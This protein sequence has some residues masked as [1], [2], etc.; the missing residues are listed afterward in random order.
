MR[1]DSISSRR[2]LWMVLAIAAVIACCCLALLTGV[3]A[4]IRAGVSLAETWSAR[5]PI[6]VT[7]SR[8][9]EQSFAVAGPARLVVDLDVGALDIVAAD[10]DTITVSAQIEVRGGNRLAAAQLLD[11][12]RFDASQSGS[13][14]TVT[15]G[16]PVGAEWR[17]ASPQIDVRITVPRRTHVT[18]DMKAGDMTLTGVK[19]DIEITADVGRVRLTNVQAEKQLSVA[20]NVAEISFSGALTADASYRLMSNVG[21]IRMTLPSNSAFAIDATS[22]VGAV[23]V[24]FDVVGEASQQKVGRSVQGVVDGDNRTTVYLRSDV[25]AIS[26]QPE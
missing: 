9:F 8:T 12:V 15:S 7:T 22:N 6:A 18:I 13:T 20:T 10:Q 19:G 24:G 17:N 26:V 4:A 25:G 21:A 3:L 1:E 14:V 2:T 11:Q 5:G 23:T 16:W